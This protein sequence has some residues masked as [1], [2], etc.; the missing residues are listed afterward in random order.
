M[1]INKVN[2]ICTVD[3]MKGHLN[4]KKLPMPTVPKMSNKYKTNIIG[5]IHDESLIQCYVV[6]LSDN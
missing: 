3:F 6:Y 5:K 4:K 1:K 2:L